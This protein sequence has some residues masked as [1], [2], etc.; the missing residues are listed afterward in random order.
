MMECKMILRANYLIIL[1][2]IILPFLLPFVETAIGADKKIVLIAGNPSHGQGHHDHPAGCLLLHKCLN[3]LPGI[4]TVVYCNGWPASPEAFKKAHA[5][6]IYSDGGNVH[7]AIRPGR[8]EY[9]DELMKKGVGLGCIHYA[10]EVPKDIG[11]S[12]FRKW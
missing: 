5:I 6:V 3:Q 4:S 7:P 11:G 9:L 12:E 8:L 2:S 10:V 1:P